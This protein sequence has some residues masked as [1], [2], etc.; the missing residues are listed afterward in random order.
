MR[1]WLNHAL[2]LKLLYLCSKLLHPQDLEET[3]HFRRWRQ[4]KVAKIVQCGEPR[5]NSKNKTVAGG[6][7]SLISP[8]HMNR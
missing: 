3:E 8:R 2:H 4:E 1:T 5:N 7:K 6:L